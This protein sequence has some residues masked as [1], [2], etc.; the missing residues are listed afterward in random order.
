MAKGLH[1]LKEPNTLSRAAG[2][3]EPYDAKHSRRQRLGAPG[4]GGRDS[5]S[6]GG[7]SGPASREIPYL[8]T[9]SRRQRCQPPCAPASSL[10]PAAVSGP[11]S[12]S[13]P[14]PCPRH[15]SPSNIGQLPSPS[16]LSLRE[17]PRP[18][19]C[20]SLCSHPMLSQSNTGSALYFAF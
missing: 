20:C 1:A 3:I 16:L 7:S 8:F 14:P 12:A 6:P 10:S 5:G 19:R 4:G 17:R 11:A 9:A 18:R 2:Y 15:P 13:S